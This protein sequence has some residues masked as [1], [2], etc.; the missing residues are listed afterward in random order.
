MNPQIS[1]INR[2]GRRDRTLDP[3]PNFESPVIE[4]EKCADCDII[5][6]GFLGPVKRIEPPAIVRLDPPGVDFP[7]CGMM[8]GFLKDLIGADADLLKPS[9]MFDR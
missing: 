8:I 7:V 9:V 3:G 6:T 2:R 4:T 5:D 1:Q